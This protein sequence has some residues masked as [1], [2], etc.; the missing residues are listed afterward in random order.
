MA[1]LFTQKLLRDAAAANEH[2][3]TQKLTDSQR[4]AIAFLAGV[5]VESAVV[6]GELTLTTAPCNVKV[7]D[8]KWVV[9]CRNAE[10]D[11]NLS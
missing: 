3:D 5:E 9:T 8:G 1:E 6:N 10:P 11:E 4:F 7:V 2:L